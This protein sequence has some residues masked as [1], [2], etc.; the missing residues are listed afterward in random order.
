M[1]QRVQVLVANPN[2]LDPH[3]SRKET[4]PASGPGVSTHAFPHIHM[5]TCIANE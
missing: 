2:D 1:D 4:T 5:H 3:G